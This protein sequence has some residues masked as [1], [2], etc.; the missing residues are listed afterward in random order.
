FITSDNRLFIAKNN[1][2]AY[3]NIAVF[4]SNLTPIIEIVVTN[5]T[6]GFDSDPSYYWQ[7]S[8]IDITHNKFYITDFMTRTMEVYDTTNYSLLKTFHFD[9]NRTYSTAAAI[10]N[11]NPTT[12]ELYCDLVYGGTSAF[13]T[14]DAPL[15]EMI[16]Y[17]INRSTL[18]IEK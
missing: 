12:M 7:N 10:L 18:D 6:T 3:R 16:S 13:T 9:N 2:S 15:T 4:N 17:K 14:D 1:V 11:I 8:F 5:A